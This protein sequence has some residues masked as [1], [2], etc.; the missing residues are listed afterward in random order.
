MQVAQG[1][2]QRLLQFYGVLTGRAVNDVLVQRVGRRSSGP[3]VQD[4]LPRQCADQ[5]RIARRDLVNDRLL[6]PFW[7]VEQRVSGKVPH[8]GVRISY[9]GLKDSL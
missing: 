7:A 6:V 9:S 3:Q 2:C 8:S 1:G 5:M 4:D